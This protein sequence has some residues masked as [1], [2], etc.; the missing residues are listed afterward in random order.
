MNNSIKIY[1]ESKSLLVETSNL[2]RDRYF[3]Q[4][5]KNMYCF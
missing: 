5:A 4:Y 3:I 2:K 1:A